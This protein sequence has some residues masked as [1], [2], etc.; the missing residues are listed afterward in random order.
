MSEQ[1][2]LNVIKKWVI[3]GVITL[4]LT[5]VGGGLAFIALA[6]KRISDL[7][8]KQELKLDK[9]E[10]KSYKELQKSEN[11]HLAEDIKEIKED[12]K[13]INEKL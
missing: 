9:Q 13:N 2:L 10:L 3:G 7:E 12:I 1:N 5:G 8:K 4:I 11:T 6:D